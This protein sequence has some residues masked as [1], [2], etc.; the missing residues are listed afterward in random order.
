MKTRG[1]GT[2]IIRRSVL[3]LGLATL[4]AGASAQPAAHLSIIVPQPA[5][6]PTDGIARKMAPTLQSALGQTVVVE[7]MPGAGGALGVRKALQSRTPVLLIASQ[8]EPILTPLAMAG[9]GY[10]AD[11]LRVVALVARAPYV[12]AGRP[13]LPATDLAELVK[14]AAGN[15]LTH[16]HIGHGS[17]IHLLGEELA[18]RTGLALD[19]VPYRGVP[20]VVQDL[21]GG[22]IDLTFLPLGGSTPSLIE[23]GKVRA[24]GVTSTEA[25]P[26]LPDV[27]PL[28]ALDPR[29]KDFVYGTWAAI[30]APRNLPEETT[31]RL[32]EA[33]K[34]AL[35][36][37]D[38]REYT[39][40]AGLQPEAALSRAQLDEFYATETRL[41]EDMAQRIGIQPQ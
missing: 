18:G 30:L 34:V 33:L 14:T 20:P 19:Q 5:G 1:K 25:L 16:G 11:D 40:A 7:N 13:N 27:Q 28:S 10:K 2:S 12:L 29:L 23:T 15:S 41:Y 26:R 21:M 37:S 39:L 8:T 36:N 17:M 35:Q 32:Y 38:V 31:Q 22:Q 4:V 9:A 6:N 24:Y 3:A